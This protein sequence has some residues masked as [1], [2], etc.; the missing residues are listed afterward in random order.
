MFHCPTAAFIP[1]VT[2]RPETLAELLKQLH[3]VE[4]IYGTQQWNRLV[5]E[6]LKAVICVCMCA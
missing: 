3:T 4:E 1:L 2:S 6:I 5:L